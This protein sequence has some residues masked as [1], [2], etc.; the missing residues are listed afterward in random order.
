MAANKLEA[1]MGELTT[2]LREKVTPYNNHIHNPNSKDTNNVVLMSDANA[3]TNYSINNNHHSSN[4]QQQHQHQHQ[5]QQD[6]DDETTITCASF[7]AKEAS[8]TLSE[9]TMCLLLDRFVPC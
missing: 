8:S 9:S 6:D 2:K 3:S 5:H 4:N 1:W 7:S